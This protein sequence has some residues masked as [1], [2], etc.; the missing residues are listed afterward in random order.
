MRTVASGIFWLVS[1]CLLLLPVSVNAGRVATD[2][3]SVLVNS[4]QP[5]FHS[6]AFAE[7][8]LNAL[9]RHTGKTEDQLRRLSGAIPADL[10]KA[11]ER[12]HF[13]AVPARFWPER[14]PLYWL[15]VFADRQRLER[16]VAENQLT[17]WPAERPT[18]TTWLLDE[19]GAVPELAINSE[20][21][22]A[23]WLQKRAEQAGLALQLAGGSKQ[24]QTVTVKAVRQLAD[25]VMDYSQSNNP[26]QPV[27]LLVVSPLNP[28]QTAS[29]L[30]AASEDAVTT[31]ND[32]PG[33]Y[34]GPVRWKMA[35]LLP[36]EAVQYK[37]G[38]AGSVDEMARRVTTLLRQWHTA[39]ERIYPQER[40]QHEIPL[41]VT[42]L[43]EYADVK[44][45]SDYLNRLSV[46]DRHWIEQ[47]TPGRLRLRVRLKVTTDAFLRHIQQGHRF[48]IAGHQP[49]TLE[50]L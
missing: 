15:H 36:G 30:P 47:A 38:Q 16:I 35:Y 6:P 2:A 44:A 43:H 22:S 8:W 3:G 4:R 26:D 19:T 39:R 40:Q 23:Y 10:S 33:V 13:E 18:V 41:A 31:N 12:Y 14:R 32:L 25:S 49:L 21:A 29:Q 50:K 45:V 1:A 11:V 17:S 37:N 9:A 48:R 27:L 42:G 20:K 7:A 34:R 46:V 24:D 28:P 5:D